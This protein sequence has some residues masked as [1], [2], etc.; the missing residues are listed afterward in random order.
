MQFEPDLFDPIVGMDPLVTEWGMP[1]TK[2]GAYYV[3]IRG[4]SKETALVLGPFQDHLDALAWTSHAWRKFHELYPRDTAFAQYGT[5]RLDEPDAPSGLFNK[6]FGLPTRGW[7]ASGTRPPLSTYRVGRAMLETGEDEYGAYRAW[8]WQGR[9]F[10]YRGLGPM[11][12]GGIDIENGLE[13]DLSTGDI[14]R[15]ATP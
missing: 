1:D 10:L 3:S 6:H 4:R 15:R 8:T 12:T 5:C 9:S 7:I 11:P 14:N 13:L 2:P